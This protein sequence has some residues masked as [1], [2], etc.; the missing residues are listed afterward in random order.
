M[1][2]WRKDVT[3]NANVP[4]AVPPATVGEN[5]DTPGD[6]D[7]FEIIESDVEP[8]GMPV[9]VPSPWSGWP[10]D[11]DT[12]LWGNRG[13]GGSLLAS[14]VDS[15]W[16]CLDLN[17]SILSTMPVYKMRGGEVIDPSPWMSNPDPDIY[18]SWE[19][20][21]KQLFWDYQLGEAFVV[22]SV[23]YR[24][25]D[26]PARFRVVPPWLVNVEMVGGRRRYNIGTL[27]VTDDILHVRYKSS[28]DAARG[29]GP[30]DS[31]APR[32]VAAGV[33]S[34][35][36]TEMV[37]GGGVPNYV[38]THPRQLTAKEAGMLLEQ[39]WVS[40][41]AHPGQPAIVSGGLGVAGI[42]T[43]SAKDMT[44]HELAQWT[45][46]RIAVLC[47]VPPPLVGLP[48]GDSM[49]YKTM[50]GSYEHHDR[51]SLRPKAKAVMAALSAWALP[52]GTTVELNRDEYTRPAFAERVAA[53]A[54][55][56]SIEDEAGRLLD[57]DGMRRMERFVGAQAPAALTGGVNQS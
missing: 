16:A 57:V 34:R 27:D 47:G 53:Y 15:A 10:A 39:W 22:S 54:Q 8:R 2:F 50:E 35:Y 33:L 11:W 12:P 49:T 5:V 40:R 36:V 43:P 44:L 6:P 1:A 19:E 13:G 20:F 32:M 7:G 31:G 24:D 48:A 46:S 56:H 14:L 4:A 28:T 51:S 30:L 18:S 45:D 23:R 41:T 52:R 9:I 25:D 21:A 3:P 37:Q 55:A 42:N 17:S 38:L 26:T 29:V